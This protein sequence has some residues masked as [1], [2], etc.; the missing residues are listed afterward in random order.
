M[1]M[2]VGMVSLCQVCERACGSRGKV[3][4]KRMGPHHRQ[5]V[6]G[7]PLFQLFLHPPTSLEEMSHR[8][9]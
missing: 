8:E 7:P 5:A 3:Q 6:A 2:S 1:P 9:S 4:C